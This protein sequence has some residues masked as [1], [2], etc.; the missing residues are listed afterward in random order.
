MTE[1]K[2]LKDIYKEIHL[3]TASGNNRLPS[4][5]LVEYENKL[6]AEAVKCAKYFIRKENE[7]FRNYS[8]EKSEHNFGIMRYWQGRRVEVIER[9]DLKEEDLE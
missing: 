9:N 7:A 8:H 3:K 5:V 2:T 6:K 4:I 1:F